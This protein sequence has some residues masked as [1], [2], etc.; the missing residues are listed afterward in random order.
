MAT[1]SSGVLVSDNVGNIESRSTRNYGFPKGTIIMWYNSGSI[2]E[3]WVECNGLRGTPNLQG[4]M[5]LGEGNGYTLNT[6]GGSDTHTLQTS[7]IPAHTHRGSTDSAGY[8]RTDWGSDDWGISDTVADNA[9]SHSHTF[10]TGLT[11]GNTPHENMP[12]F[13]TL[14][15]IMKI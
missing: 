9:G 12:P 6:S 8:G 13:Y 1:Y 7:E 10:T 4:R 3:G 5:P 14:R 11:G 2:P 15:F